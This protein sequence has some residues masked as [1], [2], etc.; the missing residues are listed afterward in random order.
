QPNLLDLLEALP[1]DRSGPWP[2]SGWEGVIKDPEG[3]ARFEKL[4]E[5]WSTSK[6]SFLKTTA[7]AAL[8]TRKGTR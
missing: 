3:I 1:A 4:L 7:A 6:S 5:R 2:A 8:R